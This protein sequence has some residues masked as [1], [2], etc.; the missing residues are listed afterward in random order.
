MLYFI[1]IRIEEIV[2]V[3]ALIHEK[4][5]YCCFSKLKIGF[6]FAALVYQ[7]FLLYYQIVPILN[8][9]FTLFRYFT[10]NSIWKSNK[11]LKNFQL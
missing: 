8:K 9:S 7:K 4:L 10:N 1:N 2:C 11:N 5:V 3:C 6:Y